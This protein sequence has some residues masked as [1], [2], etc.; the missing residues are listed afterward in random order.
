MYR[1]LYGLEYF[2]FR[3][4]NPFGI[5]RKI[6][7][8]QGVI[9]SFL[10]SYL[11]HKTIEIWGDGSVVRDYIYI[12]DVVAAFMKALNLDE[13]KGDILNIGSGEGASIKDILAII[14]KATGHQTD[15]QYKNSRNFDVPFSVL[16]ISH[17]KQILNWTPKTTL[18]NGVVKTKEWLK[19]RV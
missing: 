9:N 15:L 13:W 11:S 1:E 5:G 16:D 2:V 19:G 6:G 7:K 12:D 3:L 14:E 17:A 4:S 10:V 8:P 18:L